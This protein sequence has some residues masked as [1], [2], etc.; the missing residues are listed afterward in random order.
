M[1]EKDSELVVVR[2]MVLCPKELSPTSLYQALSP[3][4][5]NVEG[6]GLG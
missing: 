3:D 6:R 1:K 5:G 4:Q 2:E